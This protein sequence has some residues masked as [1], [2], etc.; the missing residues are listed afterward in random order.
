MGGTFDPIHYGHLAAAE[1]ARARFGLDRV[2]FVPNRHPP[3]KEERAVSPAEM[4]Y[5]MVVLATALNPAFEA[6]RIEVDRPGP[7]Y[8]ADT[9][10]RFRELLGPQVR[11]YFITGADA[12]LEITTWH[13]PPRLAGTCEFVAVMRPGYDLAALEQALGPELRA[14]TH[15]LEV[16]GVE[17]S[18]TE[19]R[20]RAAAGESLRY[21]TPPAVV[22]YIEGRGL[23]R[24]RNPG[25]RGESSPSAIRR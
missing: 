23:Y 13:D 18:S 10:E 14:R 25:A 12:V 15:M 4:R 11:L 20:R 9:M 16:P 17:V 19:L 1:E 5:E 24:S 21:L 2:I 8:S 3:H 22:S 6:S 7:S